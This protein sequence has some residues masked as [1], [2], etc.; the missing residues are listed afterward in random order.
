MVQMGSK[1]I[2]F[3][4]GVWVLVSGTVSET[5]QPCAPLSMK[6][7]LPGFC[8]I[9]VAVR[10]RLAVTEM[11]YKMLFHRVEVAAESIS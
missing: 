7:R 1:A 9:S 4:Q 10:S 3:L 2:A 5:G 8:M 6:D 11:F